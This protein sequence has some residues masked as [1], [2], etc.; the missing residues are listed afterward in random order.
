MARNSVSLG[1][2]R[3]EVVTAMSLLTGGFGE[4]V[5]CRLWPMALSRNPSRRNVLLGWIVLDCGS[6]M[7]TLFGSRM[8][9][10]FGAFRRIGLA[11]L[12]HESD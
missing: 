6:R 12:L 1:G 8:T 7:T 4:R 2:R 10:L 9:T 5:I 3:R 11:F